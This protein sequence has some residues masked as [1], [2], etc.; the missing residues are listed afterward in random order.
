MWF[1]SLSLYRQRTQRNEIDSVFLNFTLIKKSNRKF[2]RQKRDFL[3]QFFIVD[4]HSNE[5]EDETEAVADFPR[6]DFEESPRSVGDLVQVADVLRGPFAE[7]PQF[8]PSNFRRQESGYEIEAGE[9]G[10][11]M[12]PKP[13]KGKNLFIDVVEEEEANESDLSGV[14]GRADVLKVA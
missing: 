8:R 3:K 2:H 11:E 1:F 12:K 7:A 4:V 5:V 10:L 6:A 14:S 13:Q 9:N